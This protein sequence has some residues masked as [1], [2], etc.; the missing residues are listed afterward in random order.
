MDI[1]R[2]WIPSGAEEGTEK[3]KL[4][5][6]IDPESLVI[7]GQTLYFAHSG[8]YRKGSTTT[9]DRYK[10]ELNGCPMIITDPEI[11][12]EEMKRF[13]FTGDLGYYNHVADFKEE[14]K[15]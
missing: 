13:N 14:S 1:L 2:T 5:R 10:V 4:Y 7:V 12:Q 9:I 6:N 8:C 15:A 3:A 11:I